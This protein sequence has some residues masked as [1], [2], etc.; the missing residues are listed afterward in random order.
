MECE[1]GAVLVEDAGSAVLEG[2][3][4]GDL[5]RRLDGRLTT[6]A[7]ASDMAPAHDPAVVHVALARLRDRG[8]IVPSALDASPVGT[9]CEEKSRRDEQERR[10]NETPHALEAITAP[11]RLLARG[12]AR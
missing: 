3:A 8:I 4:I 1:G 6:S 12:P 2:A 7:I 10:E 5:L 11:A 9:G